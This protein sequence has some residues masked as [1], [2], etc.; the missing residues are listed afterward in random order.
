MGSVSGDIAFMGIDDIVMWLAKK[1][2]SAVISCRRGDIEKE[3]V[4]REGMLRYSSSSDPREYLGQHL[5]NFG[6]IDE[7]QLQKAFETQKETKIPM[8]KVLVMVEAVTESRLTQVLLFKLRESILE[9][10]SWHEGRFKVTDDLPEEESLDVITPIDLEEIHGEG[11]ARL[12]MWNEIRKL[13]P[14]PATQCE[15]L[16]DPEK[17]P[18][19]FDQDLLNLLKDGTSVGEC[20]LEL[21][22]MDF[23]LYARL[24]DLTERQLIRPQTEDAERLSRAAGWPPDE[25]GILFGLDFDIDAAVAE[26]ETRLLEKKGNVSELPPDESL[27]SAEAASAEAA[28]AEADPAPK[29]TAA[30]EGAAEAPAQNP[31]KSEPDSTD[32]TPQAEATEADA[33]DGAVDEVADALSA[34]FANALPEEGPESEAAEAAEAAPPS[35]A[36]PTEDAAPVAPWAKVGTPISSLPGVGQAEGKPPIPSAQQATPAVPTSTAAP[37]QKAPPKPPA[38][39][40]PLAKLRESLAGRD[41]NK[42]LLIS[43]RVLEVDPQNAEAMAARRV[44]EAQIRRIEDELPAMAVDLRSVPKLIR[45]KHEISKAQLTS[46]ERYLLSRIDGRRSLKQIVAVSPIKEAEL[47][48]IVNAF[49]NS[50]ILEL[51]NP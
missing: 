4:I 31:P 41:W 33:A 46:K 7:E 16:I 51:K 45:P 5:I 18:T 29:I 23:P 28:S 48:R 36:N 42:A 15:V 14:S 47:I 27:E 6:F 1:R 17:A 8:G 32:A 2:G 40:H 34:A 3:F 9:T 49:A 39:S 25:G 11:E 13:I 35:P 50:K 12:A 44:A 38:A 22:C 24:F 43:Q 21:R 10:L 37:A 19:P 30:A 20:A 26:E